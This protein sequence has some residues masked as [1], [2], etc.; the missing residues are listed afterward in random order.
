LGDWEKVMDGGPWNFRNFPV[1]IE[2]Y[3][4]FTKPTLIKLETISVWAQIHDVPEACRSLAENLARRIGKFEEAEPDSMDF[5]GNYCRVRVKIRVDEP[6]K[7]AVSMSRGGKREIFR[8]RYE[9][10]PAWCEVCGIL[11]HVYKEHGDGVHAD[12][13][14]K[15]GSWLLAEPSGR[16]GRGRG[17]GGLGRGAGRS[18]RG[19]GRGRGFGTEAYS[20]EDLNALGSEL[21][22]QHNKE[23][24]M[25]MDE[26]EK[27]RKRGSNNPAV[28]VNQ[29]VNQFDG[30][31]P[32]IVPPPASPQPKRDQKRHKK[33]GE[34]EI[35]ESYSGSAGSGEEHRRD[36]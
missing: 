21:L 33:V 31:S 32:A 28:T 16:G 3:D 27:N 11:G 17:R 4:G 15:F 29:L 26:A 1:C 7:R 18:D 23:T 22:L 14:R 25:E 6:L 24:D 20:E 36:Q 13:D 2:P 35:D 5:F 19:R 12:K 9:R 10:I 34:K 30:G 8:V